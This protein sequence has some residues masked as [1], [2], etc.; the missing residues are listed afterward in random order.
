MNYISAIH[1]FLGQ[2]EYEALVNTF[3]YTNFN[4]WSFV[5]Y[6]STKKS[7]NEIEKMQERFLKLFFNNAT[8]TY[9]G[10]FK[11]LAAFYGN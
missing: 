5:W 2:K 4:Y 11:I 1:S 7:T 8:D 10:R 6:F 3:V 9:V